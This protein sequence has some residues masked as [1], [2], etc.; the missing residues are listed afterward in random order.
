MEI[1]WGGGQATLRP[2]LRLHLDESTW[3]PGGDCS[4]PR[5]PLPNV[6]AA[7]K[8]QGR[9]GTENKS[10][11]RSL[12]G[13]LSPEPSPLPLPPS[14]GEGCQVHLRRF[15]NAGKYELRLTRS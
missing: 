14:F 8:V 4:P 2:L 7:W 5:A 10:L 11:N 12:L 6:P 13:A 9:R 15:H 1:H 3:Q